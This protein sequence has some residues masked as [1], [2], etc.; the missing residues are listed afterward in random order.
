M[1][2]LFFI[3][4]LTISF[5]SLYGQEFSSEIFHEGFLVTTK[6]DTIR[7]ALKYDMQSNIVYITDRGT[8][9]TFSSHKIFYFEIF[10]AAVD[11][12]RQFYSLPYKVSIGY[13]IPIL[14]ELQYEGPFSLMTREAIIQ[15]AVSSTATYWG[16]ST[17]RL[18]LIYSYYFV[19]KEG[20]M[21][22]FSGRKKELMEI[23][24]DKSKYVKEYIKEYKL[25]VDEIH[26]L[27]RVTAFYNSI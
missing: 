27:I 5:I 17:T 7:G 20:E 26:D 3:W 9:K 10:D 25:Q 19:N 24:K 18:R 22:F 4:L 13:K 2:K 12:Y 14:F 23:M 16:G 1:K 8:L 15:E 21:V 11:N 6:K